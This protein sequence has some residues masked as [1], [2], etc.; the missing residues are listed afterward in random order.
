[1]EE[2]STLDGNITESTTVWWLQYLVLYMKQM[3][4]PKWSVVEHI[5]S[6]LAS[7]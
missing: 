2:N 4:S 5:I 6:Y 7:W 3:L 1:M